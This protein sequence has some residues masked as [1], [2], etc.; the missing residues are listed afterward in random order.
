M[1]YNVIKIMSF[2]TTLYECSNHHHHHHHT[3]VME[4][5]MCLLNMI[6]YFYIKLVE[7]G[8]R[9]LNVMEWPHYC[10]LYWVLHLACNYGLSWQPTQTQQSGVYDFIPHLSLRRF[11]VNLYRVFGYNIL[12][13]VES[14]VS[15]FH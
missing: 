11:D 7:S 3:Y 14:F 15:F 2:L 12:V 1:L 4:N 9:D 13:V 5:K 6:F 10:P 8:I